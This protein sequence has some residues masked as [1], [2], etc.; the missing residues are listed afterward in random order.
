[1]V[2]AAAAAAADA[3][4]KGEDG[5][6]ATRV[7]LEELG[8]TRVEAQPSA[9]AQATKGTLI[10][11]DDTEVL[12]MNQSILRRPILLLRGAG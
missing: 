4:A 1:L 10:T 5:S 2:A 12:W 6:G 8:G 7:G 9:N 11:F 3:D